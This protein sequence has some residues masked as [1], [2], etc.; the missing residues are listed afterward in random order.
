MK[1][2]VV[3]TNRAK[4]DLKNLEKSI[5]KRI[6][7]KTDDLSEG[8]IQLQKVQGHDFYKFRV[9]HYRIFVTKLASHDTL[10]ILTIKHRKN[11]Y[12]NLKK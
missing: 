9:G 11:A 12:K 5:A 6:Y 2:F 8:K 7:L 10:L 3:W 1:L 4:K